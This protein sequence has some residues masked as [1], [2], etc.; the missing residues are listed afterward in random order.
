MSK[1]V[2]QVV[3]EGTRRSGRNERFVQNGDG[4]WEKLNVTMR[5]NILADARTEEYSVKVC[6]S[7]RQAYSFSFSSL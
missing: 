4:N 5:R 7:P 2:E 6:L 3:S 1:D